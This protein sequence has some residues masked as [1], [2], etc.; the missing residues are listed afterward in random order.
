[1]ARNDLAEV[2]RAFDAD[3]YFVLRG[4]VDAAAVD[5]CLRRLHLAIREHGLTAEEI[6]ECQQMTF[7]PHLRWEPEVWGVL[8]A[9]AA[10]LLGWRDGDEWAEPQLLLRFPDREQ[11][12]PL[13][14]HIDET[15]P[16]AG[17]RR[18]RGI[19]GV[20]LTTARSLDGAPRVWRG[21]HIGTIG[22]DHLV[23]IT[24]AAG[25]ALVMHPSLAHSGSL[26]LGSS[27]RTSVY[28]RLLEGS[29]APS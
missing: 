13:E 20:A 25:D 7:F 3:G 4:A 19:V 2:R 28:F 11:D 17:G 29:A 16:W 12:W 15:P 23:E 22:D 5:A 18:Y 27:I 9:D 8:P 6:A 21:S 24:L 1:M 14:P 10:E 26:N